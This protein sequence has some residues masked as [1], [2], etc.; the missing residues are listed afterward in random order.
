M[1]QAECPI[2]GSA[3]TAA[4]AGGDVA[5]YGC[6]R[7]GRYGLTGSGYAVRY[8]AKWTARQIANAS[9]WIREHQGSLLSSRE[10][11]Q[12][13]SL[14]TPAVSVRAMKI[15]VELEHRSAN[16]GQEFNFDLADLGSIAE[17]LAVSWT[18]NAGEL[19]YLLSFL[20]RL[21]VIEGKQSPGTRA[22]VS[23]ANVVITPRGYQQLAEM[24]QGGANS[25]I[26]FCATWFDSRLTPI[27]TEAI[28][29]AIE[30]A[31]YKPERIDSVQHNN[32]ID[33]EIVAMIRKSRFVIADFTG[34]R[35]GVYF[36]AGF[37]MGLGIP[38][39]WTTRERRLHRIHFDTRQYNFIEW[40]FTKLSGFK[41]RL[42]S[43]IEATLGSG[44]LKK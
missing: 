19:Q 35:G 5:D 27:W 11:E 14:A 41:V 32:K 18:A 20:L 26:G 28:H 38:V 10:L 23:F 13:G 40:D 30:G 33:D 1:V 9:G 17:W 3:A 21:D 34:N 42:Q 39:I 44:P 15:L 36:E 29:P 31:G 8:H 2:C 22:N 7:C 12:L 16:I 6:S 4:N 37:A 25:E 43:R 24:L